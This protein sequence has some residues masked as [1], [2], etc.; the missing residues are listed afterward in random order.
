MKLQLF[1]HIINQRKENRMETIPNEIL[2]HIF[3]YLHFHSLLLNCCLVNHR[4]NELIK[5][6]NPVYANKYVNFFAQIILSTG[7][8]ETSK[9]I[10]IYY[11]QDGFHELIFRNRV[12]AQDL[13]NILPSIV[14]IKKK[15]EGHSN[16]YVFADFDQEMRWDQLVKKF[17]ILRS[18]HINGNIFGI[19]KLKK[20]I[21]ISRRVNPQFLMLVLCHRY[22]NNYFLINTLIDT[23]YSEG[24]CDIR[25]LKNI[26]IKSEGWGGKQIVIS[27]DYWYRSKHS[28]GIGVLD[29]KNQS[30]VKQIKL[31]P[32]F[33]F[34]LN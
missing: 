9:M 21:E 14:Y 16:E 18:V 24:Q 13:S 20:I 23:H 10:I 22:F 31:G 5:N 8:W 7:Y 32:Y 27:L 15:Y 3:Q 17:W 12:N 25:R 30:Y 2:E 29:M 33:H 34:H 26:K 6:I 28:Y 1:N 4:W 19:L 11:D